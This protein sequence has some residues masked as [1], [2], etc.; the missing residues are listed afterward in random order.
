MLLVLDL[1]PL[2]FLRFPLY[3]NP[4]SFS[5]HLTKK[6]GYITLIERKTPV[7]HKMSHFRSTYPIFFEFLDFWRKKKRKKV[8]LWIPS[9]VS[10]NCEAGLLQSRLW[11]GSVSF[12]YAITVALLLK[13]NHYANPAFERRALVLDEFGNVSK[14]TVHLTRWR[15]ILCGCPLIGN[16]FKYFMKMQTLENL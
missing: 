16:F 5:F 13:R 12:H 7:N 1:Y 8:G 4:K 15:S 11:N 9:S 10:S 6:G 3:A 14:I 2:L